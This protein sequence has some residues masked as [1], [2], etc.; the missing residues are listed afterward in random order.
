MQHKWLGTEC[1]S[2][3]LFADINVENSSFQSS[4]SG[5][6]PRGNF[7]KM[8]IVKEWWL[9]THKLPRARFSALSVN[10]NIP[11]TKTWVWSGDS[12]GKPSGSVL[13]CSNKEPKLFAW[14]CAVA[15][16]VML[17]L[18]QGV[19]YK[20]EIL[21]DQTAINAQ[22]LPGSTTVN[23]RWGSVSW[24]SNKSWGCVHFNALSR[25]VYG[26]LFWSVNVANNKESQPLIM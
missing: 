17:M 24:M 20:V 2:C 12:A 11:V 13:Q 15:E 26:F 25:E 7:V 19:R 16:N 14:K 21:R 23:N 4:E 1:F 10:V 18:L 22:S 6:K 9:I 3:S 8:L 5:Y